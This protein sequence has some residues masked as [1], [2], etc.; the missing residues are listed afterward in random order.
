M[1]N[2]FNESSLHKTLKM[3][4]SLDAN[5]KTEVQKDSFIFDIITKDNSIIEI[6]TQNTEKLI[7]KIEYA[8]E[9]KINLKIV[10]P[11]AQE[12]IIITK[13][14]EDSIISKR[15]STKKQNIYN[16]F[17]NITKI[18]PYLL[19]KNIILEIL[20]ITLQETRL[21]TKEKTQSKNKKRRFKKDWIKI[22]KKL[23]NI[24]NKII[25]KNKDDYINFIPKEINQN[26]SAKSLYNTLYQ[27]KLIFK[28]Q[29]NL[30]YFIIWVLKKMNLIEETKTENRTKYYKI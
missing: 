3:L 6:Q 14:Q 11:I 20:L 4:Y 13:N 2:T 23:I 7:K 25:L 5:D 17:E 15:K 21:K 29:Q 27:N 28:N 16:I 24:N 9:N 18:A 10:F 1:I 19:E 30:C 22:D 12:K 8:I 26:F